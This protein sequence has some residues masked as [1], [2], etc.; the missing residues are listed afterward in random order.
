M[1]TICQ[2]TIITG[3]R[4]IW[5]NLKCFCVVFQWMLIVANIRVDV[6]TIAIGS[7]RFWIIFDG[8]INIGKRGSKLAILLVGEPPVYSDRSSARDISV[9]RHRVTHATTKCVV[10]LTI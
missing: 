2:A 7:C 4:E 1:A 6:S 5:I 10:R 3:A 9:F 8:F